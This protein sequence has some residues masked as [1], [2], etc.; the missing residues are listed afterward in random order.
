MIRAKIKMENG[1][2]MTLELYPETAPITVENFV[3][4]MSRW[5]AV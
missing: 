3:K 1:G 5:P 2:E 4:L